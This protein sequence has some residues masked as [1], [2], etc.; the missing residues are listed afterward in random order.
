MTMAHVKMK[1]NGQGGVTHQGWQVCIL[2]HRDAW[3]DHA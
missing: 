3:G 1:H 2:G